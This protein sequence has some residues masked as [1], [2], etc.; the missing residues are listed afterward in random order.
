MGSFE[1]LEKLLNSSKYDIKQIKKA[2]EF[3]VDAHNGQKRLSGEPYYMHPY[4]V[5]CILIELGMDTETVVAAF[6][7][8][9]VE[10]TETTLEDITK[11]FGENVAKLVDG[12]TKLGNMPLVTHEQLLSE[13]VRKMMMAMAKDI[14]VI[15]IKLADRLH[16]MRTIDAQSDVKQRQ[17]AL[18]T[19]EV[20]APIAH[21][22]GISAVKEEL[23]D[24]S[25]AH[26]D[27][28]AYNEIEKLLEIEKKERIKILDEISKKIEEH[29]RLYVPGIKLTSRVKSIHGIY[30]KMYIKGKEFGEI[31]DIYAVRIITDTVADCY[32]VLGIIHDMFQP[33]PGRFKDYISMPKPNMYQSLHTTV[34]GREGIPFEVQIRTWE[35]HHTAEYGIA[36]HWKYKEGIRNNDAK[37]EERV[38]WIREMLD[39]QKEADNAEDIVQTIKNDL[40]QE[41]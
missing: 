19:L 25:I 8:D 41:D 33:I 30:R 15:I 26:L 11:L 13:N 2:Y 5:A 37:M 38:A 1:Y 10:D 34:I 22:L 3:C 7:H 31:Y 4:S 6:L 14:R 29:I 18:E 24:I 36:A 39:N 23:E 35:M 28:V 17:K 9:V 12:V 27:P 40:S 32:N 21:R 20:Y 16:N